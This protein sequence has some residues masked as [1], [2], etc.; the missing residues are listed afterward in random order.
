MAEK[1]ID[2]F[3]VQRD[4]VLKFQSVAIKYVVGL[5]A[6]HKFTQTLYLQGSGSF[7]SDEQTMFRHEIWENL[8]E[9]LSERRA[10]AQ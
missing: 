4:E 10:T 2:N 5:F 3:Y 1:W 9:L 7:S 6:H 8:E